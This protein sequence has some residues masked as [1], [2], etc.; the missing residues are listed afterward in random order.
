MSRENKALI[1]RWFEEVWNKG[2]SEAIEEMFAA[3]GIAHGLEDAQ[4]NP[5]H[6]VEGFKEFHRNFR[7]A[8]PDFNVT[9]EDMIAEGDKVVARCRVR[10]CH[11]GEGLGMAPSQK[12]I[13]I[14]G[15]TIARI[16]AGKIA[17]GWNNFD[18]M[19]LFQQIG[20]M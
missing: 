4:G 16:E 1:S 7:S 6:G 20:A 13:D 19:K 9:I 10:A 15:I 3:E 14:T 11:T 8:F 12:P 17:E 18:F 5:I 2:R